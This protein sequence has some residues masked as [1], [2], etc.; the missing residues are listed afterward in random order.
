MCLE[1]E[2]SRSPPLPR[3]TQ[4]SPSFNPRGP[5]QIKERERERQRERESE[6]DSKF[7]LVK[8]FHIN[9]F[10]YCLYSV[11]SVIQKEHTFDVKTYQK[12]SLNVKSSPN[13]KKRLNHS[14]HFTSL[15]GCYCTRSKC[16]GTTMPVDNNH[17]YNTKTLKLVNH[18]AKWKQVVIPVV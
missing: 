9:K 14:H 13:V 15:L 3:S 6:K 18:R 4:S 2:R 5:G 8:T 1:H 7:H 10:S 17:N 16:A 11:P 12:S